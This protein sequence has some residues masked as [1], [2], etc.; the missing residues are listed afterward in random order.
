[1]SISST[2]NSCGNVDTCFCHKQTWQSKGDVSFDSDEINTDLLSTEHQIPNPKHIK[3]PFPI[4][5]SISVYNQKVKINFV[6][7]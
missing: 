6:L 7:K 5:H 2:T 3:E 4:F 1:M